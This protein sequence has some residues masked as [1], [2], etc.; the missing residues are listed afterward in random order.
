MRTQPFRLTEIPVAFDGGAF[1]GNLLIGIT[2]VFIPCGFALE[3]IY[4]RQV[5]VIILISY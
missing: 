1:G 4:D 2:Y 3:L 5:T